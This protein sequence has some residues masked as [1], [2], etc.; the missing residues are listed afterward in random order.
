MSAF[1]DLFRRV[2]GHIIFLVLMV[3]LC[4]TDSPGKDVV[5]GA[6]VIFLIVYTPVVIA[7]TRDM[8]S[9]SHHYSDYLVNIKII[10]Y[11]TF[12]FMFLFFALPEVQEQSMSLFTTSFSHALAVTVLAYASKQDSGS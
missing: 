8:Y 5:N 4:V 7:V 11:S 9:D 1:V 6:T 10:N 3:Y 2:P 12:I